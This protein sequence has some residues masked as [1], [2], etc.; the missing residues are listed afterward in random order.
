MMEYKGFYGVVEFDDDDNIFFGRVINLS[1]D[2]IT[3]Q[4]SNVDEIRQAFRESV[5]DYLTWCAETGNAPEKPYSGT[6]SVRLDPSEHSRAALAARKL[7]LSMNKFVEKALRDET[8][9]VLS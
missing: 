5:D 2:G 1:S 9:L 3:F 4:G 8:A 6:F 7:G